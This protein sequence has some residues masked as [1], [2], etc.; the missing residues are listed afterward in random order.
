MDSEL[1]ALIVEH[2]PDATIFAG[3][4]GMIQ[5]WN[6]AAERIFGH[7]KEQAMGQSLDLI[8]PENFRD[9]HWTAYDKALEAKSTKYAGQALATRSM[10]A[11]GTQ[12]YVELGFEIIKNATGEVIGALA[13]ARDI[14][15]RFN[16]DRETRQKL[17]VLEATQ[18][19][20]S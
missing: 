6:G 13:T 5:V 10:K 14:T 15:E 12:I 4:D 1:A 7:T 11:D 9:R 20:S 19:P 2:S 17:R 18:K 3:T 8:I 16:R